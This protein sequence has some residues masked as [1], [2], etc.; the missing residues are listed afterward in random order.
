MVCLGA[1]ASDKFLGLSFKLPDF[2]HHNAPLPQILGFGA[3]LDSQILRDRYSLIQ[4][5]FH[6]VDKS[7][8]FPLF[9]RP[10]T[11]CF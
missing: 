8:F 1:Q 5:F 11:A 7:H 4:Q 3:G 2:Q 6:S 9:L 10:K